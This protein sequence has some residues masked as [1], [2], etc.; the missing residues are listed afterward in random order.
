MQF[1]HHTHD[2]FSASKDGSI[3]HWDRGRFEQILYLPGHRGT[4]WS[5][6]VELEGAF[7]FSAEQDRSL[8]RWMRDTDDLCCVE[9]EKE[10][11]L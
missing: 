1:V 10:R 8:R 9:E 3:H 2:L 5:L 4:I 11:A 6:G 7:V